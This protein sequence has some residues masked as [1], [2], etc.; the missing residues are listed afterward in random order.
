MS[1]G[2][3]VTVCPALR[4][5]VGSS[6]VC[7][8]AVEAFLRQLHARREPSR[9]GVL[10]HNEESLLGIS[11]WEGSAVQAAGSCWGV[12]RGASPLCARSENDIGWR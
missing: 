12:G 10:D 4:N 9:L 7:L 11:H 2:E 3:H 1:Q 6:V 5:A 8:A